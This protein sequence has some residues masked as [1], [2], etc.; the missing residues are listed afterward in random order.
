MKRQKDE[1]PKGIYAGEIYTSKWYAA[2]VIDTNT[3]NVFSRQLISSYLDIPS[4]LD[5]CIYY[6]FAWQTLQIMFFVDWDT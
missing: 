3:A 5:L 6:N 4:Y 1:Q 2:V